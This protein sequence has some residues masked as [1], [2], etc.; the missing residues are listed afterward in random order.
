MTT[1]YITNLSPNSSLTVG[2]KPLP[3][4]KTITMD[5][6]PA[7]ENTVLS[8]ASRNLIK[9]V[10]A[11]TFN[12]V[13][14]SDALQYAHQVLATVSAFGSSSTARNQFSNSTSLTSFTS[15][16]YLSR[17]VRKCKGAMRINTVS[18]V[19]GETLADQLARW[20]TFAATQVPAPSILCLQ[21]AGNE[22]TTANDLQTVVFPGI[23]ALV[24]KALALGSIVVLMPPQ[25]D[26][27]ITSDQRLRLAAIRSFMQR[28]ALS[29]AFVRFADR[30]AYL[31]DPN[32]LTLGFPS[33]WTTDGK[34][35]SVQGAEID[36]QCL[37]DAVKNDIANLVYRPACPGLG[38]D[39][40]LNPYGNLF[41]NPFLATGTGGVAQIAG[42]TN[43]ALLSSGT[44]P[45]GMTLNKTSGS[46]T[47][48]VAISSVARTDGGPG[49]WRRFAFT[50]AANDGYSLIM[51]PS[52]TT[53]TTQKIFGMAE[54]QVD[55]SLTSGNLTKLV[56][57]VR[58]GD[59]TMTAYDGWP[60]GASNAENAEP[61]LP[62]T[63][64]FY[65][66]TP[67]N[68]TNFGNGSV[69]FELGFGGTGT[70]VLDI[71]SVHL[72]ISPY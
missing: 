2:R 6:T 67:G 4:N 60:D 47:G 59:T 57:R 16:G 1:Y 15:W 53:L 25:P 40:D 17:F 43:A 51:R 10:A 34:H 50:M 7:Q 9:A 68:F 22:V 49:Y 58:R 29:N 14:V 33:A 19:Y 71:A 31:T 63:P 32:S 61:V 27:T 55:R 12:P 24:D 39:P 37:Y 13:D 11:P 69:V 35:T 52:V 70:F 54:T 8:L 42:V 44:V 18:G 46:A 3:F 45:Q 41:V 38:Y 62:S 48:T 20:D 21:V 23:S 28:L 5:L 26:T 66:T 72:G 64:E 36:A 56:F 65:R 30:T